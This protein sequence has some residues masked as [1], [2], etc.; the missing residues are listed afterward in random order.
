MDRLRITIFN[1][2]VAVG[3]SRYIL[4]HFIHEKCVEWCDNKGFVALGVYQ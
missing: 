2:E 3:D 1:E 4:F